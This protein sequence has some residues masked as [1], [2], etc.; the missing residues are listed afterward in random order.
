VDLVATMFH[1]DFTSSGYPCGVQAP[2]DVTA[3]VPIAARWLGY[4]GLIPFVAGAVIL[5]L[6]GPEVRQWVLGMFTGY[7]VVILSFMGAVHWG[8]AM[9]TEG[10]PAT[11]QY[12]FSVLPALLA[13]S[14]LAMP[15]ALA[16]SCLIA[17]FVLLCI[18]DG[19]A[20][21]RGEAPAWYPRLRVPLTIVVVLCLIA[22]ALAVI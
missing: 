5:W 3:G 6:A 17:G 10:A 21:A 16:M 1:G 7:A 18:Y 13:W 14:A 11:R 9:R 22:A 12:A 19:A 15:P 4:A 8:L 20:A 2:T